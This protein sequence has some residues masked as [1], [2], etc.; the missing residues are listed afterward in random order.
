MFL[1]GDS[2]RELTIDPVG[3]VL[4]SSMCPVRMLHMAEVSTKG[5][6]KFLRYKSFQSALHKVRRESLERVLA[7]E[8][9]TAHPKL[10][11]ARL[12]SGAR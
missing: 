9:V 7:A 8:R 6:G 11:K 5:F 3:S 2:A 10:R 1:A 12:K 4:P